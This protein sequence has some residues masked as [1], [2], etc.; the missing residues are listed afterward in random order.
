MPGRK[1]RLIGADG[2]PYWSERLGTLTGHRR[3]KGYGRLDCPSALR[4]IAPD[5][6]RFLAAFDAAGDPEFHPELGGPQ[7]VDLLTNFFTICNEYFS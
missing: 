6:D 4:A 7:G 2:E 3:L 1:F 5:T